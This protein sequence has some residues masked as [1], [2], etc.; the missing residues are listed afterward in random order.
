MIEVIYQSDTLVAVTKPAGWI[1]HR[2]WGQDSQTVADFVRDQITGC[3]VHA[4]HRLDRGTSGVLLFALNSDTARYIQGEM[5]NNR[6]N[7]AYLAL[8]RGPMREDCVVDHPVPKEKSKSSKR[9]TA[10]TRFSVLSHKDR[11]SLVLAEPQTGRLH[12]I[13]RHLKH[14]S[15]PIIGDVRYGKGEINRYFLSE[16][17]L[18]RMALHAYQFEFAD[19]EGKTVTLRSKLP[20]DLLDPLARLGIALPLQF[21]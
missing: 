9:V 19:L 10:I 16:F 15:H 8:V 21:H 17:G 20:S 3:P 4:I 2:G 12:Q 1:V 7:K 11:W 13:R 5:E 18:N 6:F 14:L